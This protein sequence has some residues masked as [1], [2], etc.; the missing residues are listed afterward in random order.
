MRSLTCGGGSVRSVRRQELEDRLDDEIRFHVEQ[1]TEKNRRAGMTPDEARR[2]AL[3][4][5]GGVEQVRERT[6]DEFRAAPIE[7][8]AR[9]VR[10]GLRSL[11]RHPGFSAMAVLSLAIGIGANAT[12]FGVA[13]AVLFRQ[14]PLADPDT[15]VNIYE[16]EGARGVQ[17]DVL[18][19]HRGPAPG[20][21][22]G[23]QR[24]RR[25][26]VCRRANR[27]RGHG[28][29][30][31]GRG[32]DG[33]RV[34]AAR[35]RASARQGHSARGRR[36]AR[37]PSG[38]DAQPR[39][40]AARLRRRSAGG[41]THAADGTPRLHDHRRRPGRLSRRPA[42]DHAGLLRPDGHAGRAD[43]HRDARPAELPQHP[44]QGAARTRRDPSAGR[45]RRV[46]RGGVSHRGAAGGVDSLESG[47]SSCR[48]PRCRSSLE[49]IRSCARRPGC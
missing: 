15:L 39:L 8:L 45:A 22:A 23:L 31:H 24:D 17:S 28:G 37:R 27:S 47:S 33:R 43:G 9:D 18:P 14:S 20:Y 38:G 32:R 34:R 42:G 46:P 35:R 41:R 7:N 40:L 10:Y 11:R 3:I 4:R 25:V 12:I 48:P 29:H 49:W 30:R 26:D 13:H 44:R 36:R 6:R 1:Q 19:E 5:F 2:Q 21:D 16:A